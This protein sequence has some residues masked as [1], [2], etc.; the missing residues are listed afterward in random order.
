METPAKPSERRPSARSAK[1]LLAWLLMLAAVVGIQGVAHGLASFWFILLPLLFGVVWIS[2]GTSADHLVRQGRYDQALRLMSLLSMGGGGR[3][4]Y[5]RGDVLTDAGRYEEA[6][7]MLRKAINRNS[8][9]DKAL[10][11]EDLGNVLMDTG[12]F[13]EAQQCF[14]GAAGIDPNHSPW[15]TGMA[16]ALLR[17]GIYPEPALTH[18]E[19]ALDLFRRGVG[20]RIGERS[21]LGA[22]LATKAWALAACGREAEAREAIDAALKSPARKT[23][24]PLAQVHYKA[25]MSLLALSDPQGA[26]EHFARGAELDPA[27]RWGRLCAGALS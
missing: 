10:A 13:E 27:G 16:E 17:Q 19:R 23:K 1:V 9:V 26:K 3:R 7:R 4:S 8:R 21:R 6:E 11:L 5:L 20:E 25:G 22:I 14:R 15:A 12:R 2:L 24:G 18:A